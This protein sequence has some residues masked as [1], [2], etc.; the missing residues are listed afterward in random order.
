MSKSL[1][2]IFFQNIKDSDPEKGSQLLNPVTKSSVTGYANPLE[3]LPM[4]KHRAEY[5]AT[6][7]PMFISISYYFL[8]NMIDEKGNSIDVPSGGSDDK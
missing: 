5:S 1:V 3:I 7:A 2:F 4:A 6:A 8:H